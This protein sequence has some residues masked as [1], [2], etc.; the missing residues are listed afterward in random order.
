MG[1]RDTKTTMHYSLQ[2]SGLNFARRSAM[3]CLAGLKGRLMESWA[4]LKT[5]CK[6]GPKIQEQ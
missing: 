6:Q 4:T 2:R 5:G 3:V 1:A